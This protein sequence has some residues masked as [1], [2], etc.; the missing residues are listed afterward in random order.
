MDNNLKV[1]DLYNNSDNKRVDNF[2]KNVHSEYK[3]ESEYEKVEVNFDWLDLMEDTVRYI[4]NILRNPNRFIINEEEVVK[5]EQAKRI[6]VESI[7][8]LSKHT[9]FIQEIEKNGDVRPSKILN[10][11]KEESYNTYENRF[12]YT[13]IQN[14]QGFLDKKKKDLV[15]SSSLK[16]VKKCT[17]N[18]VS[19]IGAEKVNINLTMDSKIMAKDNDGKSDGIPLDERIEK[20]QLHIDDLRHTDVYKALAREHVARVIPPIKKTNVILKNVNF[21]YAM[22]LWNFLQENKPDNNKKTKS[23]KVYDGEGEL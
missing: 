14:M 3:I 1:L 19:R 6:T 13:L 7:K 17:Y 8:H 11:N 10:I 21:Q 4:D 18:A 23:N 20:L 9:N 5:V 2:N 16:D 22:K 12:I 15:A